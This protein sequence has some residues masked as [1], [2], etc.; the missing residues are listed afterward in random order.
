[1]YSEWPLVIGQC[2]GMQMTN[3]WSIS[4]AI[5][6]VVESTSARHIFEK[7]EQREEEDWPTHV[8]CKE[9]KMA[10][11]NADKSV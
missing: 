3:P 10:D 7:H 2:K 6:Q 4:T 8:E 11:Q 5:A 1:M 9:G